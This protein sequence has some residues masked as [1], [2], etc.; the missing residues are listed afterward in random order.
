MTFRPH[1]PH[2]IKQLACRVH[3]KLATCEHVV[4]FLQTV[5]REFPSLSFKDFVTA[6]RLVECYERETGGHG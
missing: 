2:V 5:D 1:D 6:V 3:A 4:E